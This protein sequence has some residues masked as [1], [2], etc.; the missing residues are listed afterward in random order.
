MIQN[1]QEKAK[2]NLSDVCTLAPLPWMSVHV[3][4]Y[5]QEPLAE[6]NNSGI[7]CAH[8][9]HRFYTP[10]MFFHKFCLAKTKDQKLLFLM[11]AI[12]SRGRFL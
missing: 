1:P 5:Y 4:G 6:G 10:F 9:Q 11:R 7:P 2:L 3:Q 8:S 12:S